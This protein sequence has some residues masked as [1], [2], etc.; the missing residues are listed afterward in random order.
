MDV[1][2]LVLC[3]VEGLRGYYV[4]STHQWEKKVR[5]K[6]SF[7]DRGGV[8]QVQDMTQEPLPAHYR[9]GWL[10]LSLNSE[11]TMQAAIK[12]VSETRTSITVAAD[13]ELTVGVLSG[14]SYYF[15]L[16]LP[17]SGSGNIRLT[18]NGT[19]VASFVCFAAQD[20]HGDWAV[21]KTALGEESFVTNSTVSAMEGTITVST[22][23]SLTL[24]W[25]SHFG[26]DV[27]VDAGSYMALFEIT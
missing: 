25:G 26:A 8:G 17:G 24:Y 1:R 4:C 15:R 27:D 7:Q 20:F 22:A 11:E 16:W 19:A 13:S 6:P 14:K 5:Q 12:T 21:P 3:D 23:G 9:G 2:D 18:L 10:N